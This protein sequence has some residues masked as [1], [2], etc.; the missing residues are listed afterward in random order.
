MKYE[1][2]EEINNLLSKMTLKEKVGQLNQKLYG[3]Q[4]YKKNGTD[5]EL[6]DIFKKEVKKY[7]GIGAIYGL[8]RA[9]PWSKINFANGISK[10][11]SLNVVNMI[12]DYIRENTRMKIPVLFTEECSHGHQS[13]DGEMFP[14]NIGIGATWNLELIRETAK[15][16]SHELS[17]KGGN[18][19]LV[20]TMDV[21]RD[22]RWGRAEECFSEDPYLCSRYT[23]AIVEGYQG[24]DFT[25]GVGVVLKHLCAQGAA[26][27]GHNSGPA[28]IGERELREIFLPPVEAGAESGAIG[29]MAAYNEI[30]GIPCHGNKQLL[31]DIL[32]NEYKFNG[33]VM[34]D[35]CALD[36]LMTMTGN[37]EIAAKLAISSG[38]DLSLWDDVYT[39]LEE[40]VEHKIV[41]EHYI[42]LAV[43][44]ILYVKYKLGLFN[45]GNRD[46]KKIL[47]NPHEINK[48][49]A[50]ESIVMLKNNGALPLNHK[51][52]KIAV[53]GPNAD[54][55]YNQLGDYTSP[56][57]EGKVIT[58][59]RGIQ[60]IAGKEIKVEY[61]KGCGIRDANKQGFEEAIKLASECEYTILAIGG[62][63]AREFEDDFEDNGAAVINSETRDVN[64]GEN[65][66]LADIDLDGLQDMLLKEIKKTGTKVIAVLIQGRP[67]S[68]T[69]ILDYTD[70]ILCGWYPGKLGGQVIAETIF[71][72]NNP[73]GKLSVSI[74]RSSAQLPCYY[75]KKNSGAKIDYI[76][77]LGTSLFPFGFGLSYTEFL[78]SDLCLSKEEVSIKDLLKGEEI[79]VSVKVKNS[80]HLDGKEII[81]LYIKDIEASVTRRV[82]ELKGFKKVY[83]KKRE[84]I[85]VSLKL[86]KRELS[87]W[88]Y[89]MEK[90]IEPGK[91]MIMVGKN[92]NEYLE[93]Q[94]ILVD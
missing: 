15:Y 58:I 8:F 43:S 36:R 81:Q 61:A 46:K 28:S 47:I 12:Q 89:N 86:T 41:S 24:N 64:C 55:V 1:F 59:L 78:Y 80:G 31:T 70:A 50:A 38:V 57:R 65:V 93:K 82:K 72:I 91:V 84:E 18:L 22:P 40:A 88:N 69:N 17:Q 79:L 45:K 9:D 10:E 67:H 3:W 2:S 14:C 52:K 56:Q 7:D 23:E 74:P 32:R 25:N 35:G 33:I 11:D 71:G 34:A 39:H 26:E 73:S 48:R 54:N 83:I 42:D 62:S 51:K 87:I 68:I 20:S 53:I 66:D 37:R 63:S 29:V 19:A 27:G 75:N 16:I 4:V 77:M 30:D 60:K 5:Y 21:L 6:T 13:L 76:D 49:A 92:S 94:L 44:R 85:E 90:I